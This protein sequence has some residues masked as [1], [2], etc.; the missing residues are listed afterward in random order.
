MCFQR[1]VLKRKE[2]GT[3]VT[4]PAAFNV[5]DNSAADISF[6]VGMLVSDGYVAYS[7]YA[8]KNAQI[9]HANCWAHGRRKFVETQE[10]VE[11]DVEMALI[12]DQSLAYFNLCAYRS[13]AFIQF[14]VSLF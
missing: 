13:K 6:P 8:A 11:I 12:G 5:L 1:P 7:S 2:C 3:R 9:T 10:I 14:L 4:T